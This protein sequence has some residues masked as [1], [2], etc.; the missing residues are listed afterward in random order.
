MIE[1][2]NKPQTPPTKKEQPFK[3]PQTEQTPE[4]FA[5]G[6]CFSKLFWL[7]VIGNV[8]G[9]IM[10]T[11]WCLI[12]LHEFQMRVGL[13]LGPFIPI[14]GIGAVLITVGLYKII[15]KSD[16]LIFLCS[17]LIG[18]V[19]EYFCSW[20]QEMV[21]HTVSWDYSDTPFNFNGRTNLM[22]MLCWGLLGLVWIRIIYPWISRFIE[23]LPVKWGRIL[24][25]A[26]ILFFV[27][28]IALTV[29]AQARRTLRNEY[30]MLPKT[31][32]GQILD[33]V[34]DDKTLDWLFPNMM[35]AP[36]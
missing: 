32:V 23:M 18:G 26:L 16:I 30:H 5:K 19:F 21:F 9:C 27:F 29:L 7:F 34:Y 14:Y 36:K 20:A 22:F 24:T 31:I 8:V 1:L 15:D 25:R 35:P 33:E 12:T 11:F 17:G 13:V 28:D 6:M 10:E 2:K 3:Q 4:I